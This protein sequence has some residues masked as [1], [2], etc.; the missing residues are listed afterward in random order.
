M[1]NCVWRRCSR[2]ALFASL[3][4]LLIACSDSAPV[5]HGQDNPQRLS[6]WGLFSITEEA[7]TPNS[8]S[9]VF[10]PAN[11]LFT[12]YAQ[13][14]R[15]VWIPEGEQITLADGELQYPVGAILTK[16]FYY[17]AN[18]DGTLQ[19]RAPFL[20]DAIALEQNRVI[21]TRLLVHRADGWQAFP[22]VWNAD[23]TE[24]FL[25]VAGTSAMLTLADYPGDNEPRDF[26]YFVP[27]ENQCAGCHVTEHPDGEMH[28]LAAV[29]RQLHYK[30]YPPETGAMNLEVNKLVERGWLSEAPI[31]LETASYNQDIGDLQ[32]RATEYL[33]IN[34]GHC[35]NPNG[36]ADTSALILDGSHSSL[37]GMGRCKPPVAAGGGAGNLQYSIVP[38]QPEQSILLYRMHSTEPDEM[39]PELGRSL[40][41]EEGIQLISDWIASLPGSCNRQ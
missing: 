13:K 20:R 24:A 16:T 36:A 21:E 33:N 12:D 3:L 27:N 35:H 19:A 1:T 5:F 17:P 23:A 15:T 26:N 9:V 41:H 39:M 29:A 14:L 34:C 18:D 2:G 22:Y 32:A 4:F 37:V 31:R 11:Q 25:R 6:E 28:P 30:S 40:V 10:T 38:G 8:A 7:L